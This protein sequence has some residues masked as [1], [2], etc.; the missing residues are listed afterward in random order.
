MIKHHKHKAERAARTPFKR[1]FLGALAAAGVL[2]AACGWLSLHQQSVL[3][4]E[5]ELDQQV[6]RLE[7][8]FGVIL[9]GQEGT[10]WQRPPAPYP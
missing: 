7:Q 5:N 8:L 6:A 4:R 2:A 10:P 9:A 3:D 1:L